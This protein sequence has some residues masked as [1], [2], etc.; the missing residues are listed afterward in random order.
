MAV[1]S[2][3]HVTTY[4]YRQP[5][6]LGEHRMMFLPLE[7][8]EQRVI[9]I[10]LRI[11]P[12]P[13]SLNWVQDVF[14]NS[15]G[16]ARFSG[17][18]KQL[19]FDSKIRLS[20]TP[21][22]IGDYLIEDHAQLYPFSY[23][24]IDMPDLVRLIERPHHDP[25]HVVDNWARKFLAGRGQVNTRELLIGITAAIHGGFVY[26]GREA[27]GTQEPV[28]TLRLGSG[29]CRDFAVLM[30]DAAR[31]LGFATRFVSGYLHSPRAG[32][33]VGGGNTHA[34]VQVYL[35][36]A[37]W[38]EF[39]P[40]NGLVGNR[41]LIRTAVV[42]DPRQA[43]PLSGTYTGLPADHLGMRVEVS[44]ADESRVADDVAMRHD[45]RL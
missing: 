30:M 2:V 6:G 37:G 7:G 18:A 17:R 1:L 36:G 16:V 27:A 20:H 13:T 19:R 44:V 21:V 25:D 40:T 42:R 22:E 11:T 4:E 33:H 39:D 35:P 14:G 41:N 10:Q 15:I 45:A 29:T 23:G 28:Q 24:A 26:I 12:E 43:V 38:V 5:V 9:D 34:W 32:V 31:S 3:H 8:H